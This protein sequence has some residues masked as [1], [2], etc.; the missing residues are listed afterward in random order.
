MVRNWPVL[1]ELIESR[2]KCRLHYELSNQEVVEGSDET[3]RELRATDE[4]SEE[5]QGKLPY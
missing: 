3:G 1:S 4:E 2:A 5:E